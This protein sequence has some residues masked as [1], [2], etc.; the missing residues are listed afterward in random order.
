MTTLASVA[1]S[2]FQSLASLERLH[3]AE[4]NRD[5]AQQVLD[6]VQA[7][8]DAGVASPVELA[9]QK[10]AF[11]CARIAIIEL[12]QAEVETV[13]ALSLL[14]GKLPEEFEFH[15][16][17]LDDLQEPVLGPGLP[18][19]LLTRRPDIFLAEANLRSA[20]ADVAV[21]RAAMFPNISL[22]AG[23]GLANPALPA[24][25]LTIPGVGPT[26][27]LA[28]NITQPIFDHDK[29]KAQRDEAAAKEREVLAAY[30]SSIISA[31]TDVENTLAALAHLNE[32]RDGQWENLAESER[33]FAGAKARYEAGSG[34]FL[35]LLEAQRTLYVVRDQGV[36]YRLARLQGWVN[37]C[38]ALGGGWSAAQSDVRTVMETSQ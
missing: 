8:F 19:E 23:A 27:A 12:K 37:L 15:S 26:L 38:K 5:A 20:R 22:T 24:T 11:A 31:F 34:D 16:Q 1:S 17:P 35:V 10:S 18:S 33:A 36:Q 4:A 29:L 3:I 30:R 25:V 14:L 6:V 9:T 7:R 2:Y 28:G 21:A 32:A 13:A